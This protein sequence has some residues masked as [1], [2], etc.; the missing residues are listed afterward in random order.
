M[1]SNLLKSIGYANP[2]S[3]WYDGSA[4]KS[5]IC[6]SVNQIGKTVN[7]EPSSTYLSNFKAVDGTALSELHE[8]YRSY[9]SVIVFFLS[10]ETFTR[11]TKHQTIP[12]RFWNIFHPTF[13][14]N[15]FSYSY[16][17][18]S[19]NIFN[20]TNKRHSNNVIVGNDQ[21]IRL[22]SLTILWPN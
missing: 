6:Q 21:L 7:V 15:T 8:Y 13:G 17:T 22:Y 19:C 18:M 1:L 4:E 2:S 12:L 11:M 9:R 14:A 3:L 20:S 10:T 5:F 16:Q